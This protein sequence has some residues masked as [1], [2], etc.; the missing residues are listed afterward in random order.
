MCEQAYRH[1]DAQSA[2]HARKCT[3]RMH[4]EM[5]ACNC[6]CTVKRV[7]RIMDVEMKRPEQTGA[8]RDVA[9][10]DAAL[11]HC[12]CM[13]GQWTVLCLWRGQG[14]C[15]GCDGAANSFGRVISAGCR[16]SLGV[17]CGCRP[18]ELTGQHDGT[19]LARDIGLR[20]T[21]ME[22][23]TPPWSAVRSVVAKLPYCQD[24]LRKYV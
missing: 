23:C 18:V 21:Y 19:I 7:V 5:K 8:S 9:L 11:Y 13:H 3:T 10:L 4:R 20:G 24:G 1:T 2:Q 15:R 17:P 6:R 14:R 16:V 12:W 22:P